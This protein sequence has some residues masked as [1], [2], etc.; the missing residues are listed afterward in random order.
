VRGL[1][2]GLITLAVFA[3]VLVAADVGLRLWAQSW[4]GSRVQEALHLSER[5]SVSF[6]GF[7][8]VVHALSGDVPSATISV[9]GFEVRSVPF[10]HGTLHL[11]HLTFSVSKLLSHHRGVIRVGGGDGVLVMTDADITGAFRR[12]GIDVAVRLSGG[13]V[14][15]SSDRIPG[16]EA[17]ATARIEDGRLILRPTQVP[18]DFAL[19]LPQL[20]PGVTYREVRIREGTG[21]LLLDIHDARLPVRS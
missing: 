17:T 4:V 19:D 10:T 6:G 13:L 18:V 14:H 2:R 1:R 16:A 21:E 7:P 15:V 12:Q 3:A 9:D 20:A 5:P 11:E 8:F